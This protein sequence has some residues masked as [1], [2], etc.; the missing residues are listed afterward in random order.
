MITRK[1]GKDNIKL[2]DRTGEEHINNQ[3]CKFTI[4]E[5]FTRKNC[6]VQFDDGIIVSNVN[7][8]N[9]TAGAVTNPNHRSVY[10]IGYLGIGCYNG[11]THPKAKNKWNSMFT[12]CYG[13][14][15]K[16]PTYV[17]CYVTEEWHNFQVFAEWF[18]NNYKEGYHL[19]KDLLVKNNRIYSPKTCVFVP[20][21]INNLLTIRVNLRGIYPIGVSKNGDKFLAQINMWGKPIDLELS[22]T[23]EEAF[24]VYKT[25]KEQYIKEVAE[26]WKG[27]IDIR[28]YEAMHNYIVE[29]TD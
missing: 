12:R 16:R 13:E 5:Y 29:I 11:S 8:S 20:Q 26:E 10:G 28:A 25:A 6:T 2:L 4:I 3:G 17:D 21:V 27:R 7:Y 24:I 15:Y 18:E 22:D 19:D 14:R 9:I 1:R 23:P